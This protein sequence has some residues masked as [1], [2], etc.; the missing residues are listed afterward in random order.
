MGALKEW[1]WPQEFLA[2]IP[3]IVEHVLPYSQFWHA[4][5]GRKNGVSSSFRSEMWSSKSYMDMHPLFVLDLVAGVDRCTETGVVL[6]ARGI[7]LIL[8]FLVDP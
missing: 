6:L 2:L 3:D 4:S 7:T 8:P 1:S 5:W